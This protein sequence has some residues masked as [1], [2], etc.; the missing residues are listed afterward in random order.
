MRND[1]F[2]GFTGNQEAVSRALDES[3]RLLAEFPDHPQAL[4]WHGAATLARSQRV[5]QDNR[6]AGIATFQKGIAEM[7]RA[8]ELAPR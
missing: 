6:E 3:E 8:V 5:L 4:V 1:L 2:A 7:D